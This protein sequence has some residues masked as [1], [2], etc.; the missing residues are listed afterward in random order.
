MVRGFQVRKTRLNTVWGWGEHTFPSLP[1]RLRRGERKC[2][3]R[4]NTLWPWF[5]H[6]CQAEEVEG[7]ERKGETGEGRED[8]NRGGGFN[9]ISRG[10]W[11]WNPTELAVKP[12]ERPWASHFTSRASAARM[13]KAEPTV[14]L[15]WQ[16]RWRTT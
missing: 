4:Q 1:L 11:L 12:T 16:D 9:R 15:I 2:V 13:W 10:L 3:Q 7:R 5:L 8:T 14:L 6:C